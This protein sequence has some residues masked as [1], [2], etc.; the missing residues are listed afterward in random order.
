[1]QPIV[2]T[3]SYCLIVLTTKWASKKRGIAVDR[4]EMM[5]G[6]IYARQATNEILEPG[7]APDGITQDEWDLC[8]WDTVTAAH[9]K[10]SGE[11]DWVKL[12]GMPPICNVINDKIGNDP[13]AGAGKSCG[14]GCIVY[15]GLDRETFDVMADYLNGLATGPL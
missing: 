10:I 14:D 9:V 13:E 15:E 8:F 6:N 7:G 12:E 4:A 2:P 5:A 1:M 11:N 3:S